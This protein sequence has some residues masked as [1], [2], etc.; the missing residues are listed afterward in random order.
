MRYR[1]ELLYSLVMAIVAVISLSATSQAFAQRDAG[2]KVRG[3]FG[4]GYWTHQRVERR[5][6]HALD[7]AQGVNHYARDAQ[8]VEPNVAQAE[9]AELGRNLKA[10]QE[11][12]TAIRK[13]NSDDK[14]VLA[15]VK[16]IEDHLASAAAQHEKL[17]AVCKS[18]S[19]DN[20]AAMECCNSITKDL[21]KAISEHHL[22]MKK[23]G[24]E[25]STAKPH[26]E[27]HETK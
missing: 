15:S 3:E 21:E 6:Q 20:A 12:L 11:E 1:R 16:S 4:T 7:Y 8:K 14:E 27:S 2:A 18:E 25:K 24:I 9:S 19:V 23:L 5:M 17:H 26:P 13:A 10:A 22:L